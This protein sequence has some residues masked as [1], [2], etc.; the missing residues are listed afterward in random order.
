MK[1]LVVVTI[2]SFIACLVGMAGAA[3][4]PTGVSDAPASKVVSNQISPE[5]ADEAQLDTFV[6]LAAVVAATS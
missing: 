4:S 6:S 1:A 3:S 5:Q 2:A